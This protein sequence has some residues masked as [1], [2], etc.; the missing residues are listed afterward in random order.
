MSWAIVLLVTND[1]RFGWFD[2]SSEQVMT[3][4]EWIVDR[5]KWLVAEIVL[6]EVL[7][8]FVLKCCENWITGR[9]Q[10]HVFDLP[11]SYYRDY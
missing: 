11:P 1:W 9:L 6:T 7:I 3:D 8:A 2:F 4:F 10:G 5:F